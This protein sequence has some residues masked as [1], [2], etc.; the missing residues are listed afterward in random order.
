MND[1]KRKSLLLR[2]KIEFGNEH[3]YIIKNGGLGMTLVVNA[4]THEKAS[5]ARKKIPTNWEELYVMVIYHSSVED[6]EVGK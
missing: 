6:K 2:A 5:I 1:L 4:H 3:E